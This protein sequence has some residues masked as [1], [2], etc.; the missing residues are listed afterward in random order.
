MF[1]GIAVLDFDSA[2]RRDAAF[3]E[4]SILSPMPEHC[5]RLVLT[6]VPQEILHIVYCTSEQGGNPSRLD[7]ECPSLTMGEINLE[8]GLRKP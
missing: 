2:S 1:S 4:S 8:S 6:Q 5:F 7:D 3:Y